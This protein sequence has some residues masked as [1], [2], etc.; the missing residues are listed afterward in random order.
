M[1]ARRLLA[2]FVSTLLLGTGLAVLPATG[3]LPDSA[4][5][6]PADPATPV[7][8]TADPLPTVQIN[9]VAWSQVVVGDVVYVAG[10]FT[11]ARPA[12]APAGVNEVPRNNVL[13]YDVRTGA[14]IPS[15]APSLNGQALSITASPDGSRIYVGG[16]F[17]QV[18]G[19]PRS[20]IAALTPAGELVATWRP[21][22]QGQVRAIAATNDFVYCG[23]NVTAVGAVSRTR[24]A[25]VTAVD[26]SLT[27]W[28]PVPGYGSAAGN[29]DGNRTLTNEVLS[30]VL[31]NGNTQLVVSGRFDSMNG[32]RATGRSEE[33]TSELQSRQYLVCR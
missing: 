15:F 10:R 20:R 30:M 3:A 1:H 28:A 33:H 17:T 12:G 32:V 21:A 26:G 22:V 31:T 25:V 6:D 24:L 9:G 2:G 13:A 4:P 27:N 8:V 5:L 18:N 23:G 19:Q 7:T 16:D 14:L 11:T 29:T